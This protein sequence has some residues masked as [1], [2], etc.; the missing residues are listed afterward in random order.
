MA[1]LLDT[2][3][4]MPCGDSASASVGEGRIHHEYEA[5]TEIPHGIKPVV[6][7]SVSLVLVVGRN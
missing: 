4:F 5:E 7:R 3:G 6:S 1:K 2:T